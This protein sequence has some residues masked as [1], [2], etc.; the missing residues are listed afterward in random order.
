MLDRVDW[1]KPIGAK[2]SMLLMLLVAHYSLFQCKYKWNL[3]KKSYNKVKLHGETSRFLFY[4]H[5][6]RIAHRDFGQITIP[7]VED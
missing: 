6:E 3:L 5:I 1:G 2:S 7:L 4:K